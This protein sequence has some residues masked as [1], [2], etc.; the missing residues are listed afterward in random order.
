[1]IVG[2][3]FVA[4]D[5]V[6]IFDG[7]PTVVAEIDSIRTV[8]DSRTITVTALGE[9]GEAVLAASGHGPGFRVGRGRATA[10][11]IINADLATTLRVGPGDSL[12]MVAA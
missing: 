4:G 5:Y 12:L 9:G 10:E 6:D 7:G 3:G 2:E 1:M 8:R 11:G